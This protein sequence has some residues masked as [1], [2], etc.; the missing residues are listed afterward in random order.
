MT[1]RA[2]TRYSLPLANCVLW[3]ATVSVGSWPAELFIAREGSR[4]G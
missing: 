1:L 2:V 3:S 4:N